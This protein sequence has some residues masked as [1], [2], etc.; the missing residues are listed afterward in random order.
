M[1]RVSLFLACLLPP[2]AS[3]GCNESWAVNYNATDADAVTCHGPPQH[4]AFVVAVP[5]EAVAGT[6]L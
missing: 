2:L 4:L 5:G 1:L 6:L 3:A